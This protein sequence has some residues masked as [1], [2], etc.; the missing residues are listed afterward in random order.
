MTFAGTEFTSSGLVNS[1]TVTSATLTSSGAGA[2]ATVAGSPYSIVPSAAAGSGLANYA[3]TYGAGN[4]TVNPAVLTV[5]ANNKSKAYGQMITFSGSNLPLSGLLNSDTVTSATLGSSGAAASATVAGSPYTII[6]SGAA[7]TGLANYSISYAAGTL[8]ISPSA[9]TVTAN[10]R[11]KTYGQTLTFAGTEFTTSG[12]HNSDT[13]SSATLSSSGAAATAAV[14]GS[15]YIIVSQARAAGTGLNN[16]NITYANGA[17]TVN[18]ASLIV[19]ANNRSKTYGQAVTFS[20][21]S[22]YRPPACSTATPSA[23]RH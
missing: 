3:I 2:A 18:A 13:V 19:T 17:L 14:N 7:G 9:L 22:K 4:L 8:T 6:P 20:R 21:H 1:D 23:A 12:L 15:P 16:Y 10:N 11:T 5:T